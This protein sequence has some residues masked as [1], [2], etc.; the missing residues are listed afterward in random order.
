MLSPKWFRLPLKRI[1][2]SFALGSWPVGIQAANVSCVSCRAN[3]FPASPR[4]HEMTVYTQIALINA[5][6][7]NGAVNR[8]VLE[9]IWSD[10]VDADV[11][12][13]RAGVNFPLRRKLRSRSG[14]S[15]E[16]T[17]H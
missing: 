6:P 7:L 13:Y 16:S 9:Y 8:K 15:L 1:G 4:K 3:V 17:L 5:L 11:S 14:R 2:I 12:F 10:Y